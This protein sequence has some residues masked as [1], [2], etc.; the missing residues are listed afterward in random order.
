MWEG[1]PADALTSGVD[2]TSVAQGVVRLVRP[3]EPTLVLGSTQDPSVVNRDAVERDGVCVA[4]R[5]TGGGAVLVLPDDGS[6]WIDVLLPK[7]P[8]LVPTDVVASML[9]FG[10]AWRSALARF[11]IAASVAEQVECAFPEARAVCFAALVPGELLVGPPDRAQKLVG[12]AQRR[13]RWT[14]RFS[15]LMWGEADPCLVL[16]YL[17]LAEPILQRL[18][19]LL[20][21]RVASG[22][23]HGEQLAHELWRQLLRR[24]RSNPALDEWDKGA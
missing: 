24:V 19:V 3:T 10:D 6:V 2:P 9:W 5:S 16:R 21:S 13:S 23:G 11:G 15:S 8:R 17:R 12:S 7:W 20:S 4:R 14:V 18:E 1:R 22:P